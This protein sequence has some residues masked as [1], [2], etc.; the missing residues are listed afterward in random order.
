MNKE[1]LP[2]HLFLI[3]DIGFPHLALNQYFATLHPLLGARLTVA[4]A[5]VAIQGLED[6]KEHLVLGLRLTCIVLSSQL[7]CKSIRQWTEGVFWEAWCVELR[8]TSHNHSMS[9]SDCHE[10]RTASW[11]STSLRNGAESRK[12]IVE[13]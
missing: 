10:A 11:Q 4:A 1:D 6:L 9:K 13:S 3:F 2:F 7:A 8:N 12:W 5:L